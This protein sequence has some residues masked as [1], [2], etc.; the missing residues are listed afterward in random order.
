M[1]VYSKA[2]GADLSL[3]KNF[4]DIYVMGKSET[5]GVETI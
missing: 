2:T 4:S 3:N 5:N 1:A